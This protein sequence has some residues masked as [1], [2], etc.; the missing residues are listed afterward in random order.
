ML[1]N[2]SMIQGCGYIILADKGFGNKGVERCNRWHL[3]KLKDCL[4][5]A[6]IHPENFNTVLIFYMQALV[7]YCIKLVVGAMIIIYSFYGV[8]VYEQAGY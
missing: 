2:I 7:I 3:L 5:A 4:T 6:E 1:V 8:Y